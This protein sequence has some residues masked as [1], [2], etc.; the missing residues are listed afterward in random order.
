VRQVDGVYGVVSPIRTSSADPP[1]PPLSE[2]IGRCESSVLT[3]VP[4]LP[5]ELAR[6]I[7]EYA[8]PFGGAVTVVTP[9][10]LTALDKTLPAGR[11]AEAE[12]RRTYAIGLA[13][14]AT[15][16][17]AGAGPQLLLSR[18]DNCCLM[19]VDL[20]THKLTTIAGAF[21]LAGH[22][23]GPA[24]SRARFQSLRGIAVAP[25]GVT[26]VA[27]MVAG[28][29]RR[30]S[31]A[32]RLSDEG[33]DG[34]DRKSSAERVVRTLIGAA[35]S[36]VQFARSS[37]PSFQKALPRM[38]SVALHVRPPPRRSPPSP[39][40]PSL[41]LFH[42]TIPMASAMLGACTSAV[43]SMCTRLTWRPASARSSCAVATAVNISPLPVW[44]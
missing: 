36:N 39:P 8:R 34:T 30:I 12:A 23:D 35:G 41:P 13:I 16:A 6:L 32:K 26:F 42:R 21:D 11:E 15:D 25:N 29:V 1:P 37:A 24:L 22:V 3:A 9:A 4:A 18:Y 19:A 27:D 20:R 17:I 5:K 7:A 38:W 44:R 10:D 28:A 31:A 2:L 43:M 33:T 14:D 40:P